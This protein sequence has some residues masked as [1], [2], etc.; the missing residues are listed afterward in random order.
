MYLEFICCYET[1]TLDQQVFGKSDIIK[2][3]RN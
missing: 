1:F 2:K 3:F